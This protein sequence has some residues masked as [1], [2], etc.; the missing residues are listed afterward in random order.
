MISKTL[1]YITLLI[2]FT[3]IACQTQKFFYS[4]DAYLVNIDTFQINSY[5]YVLHKGD[6]LNIEIFSTDKEVN[7]L[8]QKLSSKNMKE[9]EVSQMIYQIDDSGYIVIPFI[10]SIYVDSLTLKQAQV[11]IQQA[12][13]KVIRDAIVFVSLS[14]NY[15]IVFG[16]ANKQGKFFINN[17][18]I[19]FIDLMALVNGFSSS[20]DL[21][22]VQIYRK[23]GDKLIHLKYNL[24]SS[25]II[26]SK[27]FF[28]RG[29]DI[30]FIPK[31]KVY[32]F[33]DTFRDYFYVVNFLTT[34]MTFILLML[35]Y[36][37]K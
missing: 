20:A 28:I 14:N 32:Y 1:K 17:S 34:A 5:D 11:K 37:R 24:A 16:E 13:S 26:N 3:S 35:Q 19:N 7:E 29:G 33:S 6:I 2:L 21:K 30:I 27:D 23:I 31:K 8:L 18:Q 10:A 22:N 4:N 25:K 12:V 36:I 15:I 9:S